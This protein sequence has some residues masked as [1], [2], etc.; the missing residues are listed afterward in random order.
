MSRMWW[1]V[2]V[3]I[4]HK[5]QCNRQTRISLCYST[6]TRVNFLIIHLRSPNTSTLDTIQMN[7][8]Q[9]EVYCV[10]QSVADGF[11][12]NRKQLIGYLI[13]PRLRLVLQCGNSPY[14]YCPSPLKSCSEC[15]VASI[16]RGWRKIAIKTVRYEGTQCSLVYTILRFLL[17]CTSSHRPFRAMTTVLRSTVNL[18]YSST[19]Q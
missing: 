2:F 17:A 10:C 3:I 8:V 11:E 5:L 1:I 19:I 6:E 7:T 13:P 18:G 15:K 4:Q 16:F 12:K 9:S 14:F